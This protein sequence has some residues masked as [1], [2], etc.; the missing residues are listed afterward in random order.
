MTSV[1]GYYGIQS[2]AGAYC[3]KPLRSITARLN[4]KCYMLMGLKGFDNPKNIISA[5]I[6]MGPSMRFIIKERTLRMT[7]D[8]QGITNDGFFYFVN[9]YPS[10]AIRYSLFY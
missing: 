9:R 7:I 8:E 6:T 10:I 4:L 5:R 1:L 2:I 3:N